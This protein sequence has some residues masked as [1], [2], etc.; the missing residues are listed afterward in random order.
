MF[1]IGY[2]LSLSGNIIILSAGKI[3]AVVI[4]N[5]SNPKSM[6]LSLWSIT[7]N[8]KGTLFLANLTLSGVVFSLTN[9]VLLFAYLIIVLLGISLIL[10]LI[11][12]SI[13]IIE[14]VAP[15]SMHIS[16]FLW[17]IRPLIFKVEFD[18]E[19]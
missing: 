19:K 3:P 7:I 9:S 8:S 2:N 11:A 16:A 4:L 10:F 5:Q 1:L 17:F 6:S 15:Q 14:E 13:L 12:K 18:L